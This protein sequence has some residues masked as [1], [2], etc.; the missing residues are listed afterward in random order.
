MSWSPDHL[1]WTAY[2]R[3]KDESSADKLLLRLH[4]ALGY[5]MDVST[6]R[7]YWKDETLYQCIFTTP[8]PHME[9]PACLRESVLALAGS[10]ASSGT[11]AAWG[12]KETFGGGPARTSWL[13]V[14]TRSGLISA[15][16][17]HQRPEPTTGSQARFENHNR[18]LEPR[19]HNHAVPGAAS[20]PREPPFCRQAPGR[21]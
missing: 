18:D 9:K 1:I 17:T 10:L 16:P 20:T 21:S 12:S 13:A 15:T 2:L 8:L 7:R 6:L 11:S 3:A 19:R 5:E 4:E 14:L